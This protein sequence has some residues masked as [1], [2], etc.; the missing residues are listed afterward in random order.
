MSEKIPGIY[1]SPFSNQGHVH[2]SSLLAKYISELQFDQSW[3]LHEDP[4]IQN[5]LRDE[6]EKELR[7]RGL[8][9]DGSDPFA[10]EL[11][12]GWV[13][14]Q[15][16]ALSEFNEMRSPRRPGRPS[17]CPARCILAALTFA[18]QQALNPRVRKH[19]IFLQV[20]EILG[21]GISARNVQIAIQRTMRFLREPACTQCFDLEAEYGLPW[22]TCSNAHRAA[23][24]TFY[25]IAR[26][27]LDRESAT[28]SSLN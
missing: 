2:R 8:E 24:V 7:A 22:G 15:V 3:R 25:E 11:A 12:K 5:L 9:V 19:T 27:F 6:V 4:R 18:R 16:S 20:A 23:N 17:L 1:N 13:F 10:E 21:P 26:D 28:K 14:R